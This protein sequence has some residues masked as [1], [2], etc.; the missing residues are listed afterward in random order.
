MQNICLSSTL[1]TPT[2]IIKKEIQTDLYKEYEV[3]EGGVEM[4]LLAEL[5]HLREVLVVDVRVH[6]EQTLQDRLRHREEVLRERYS[7]NHRVFTVHYI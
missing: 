1:V 6:A 7:W 2:N 5:D 3:F 4:R